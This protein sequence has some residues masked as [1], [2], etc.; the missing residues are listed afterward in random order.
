ML[1]NN[2]QRIQKSHERDENFSWVVCLLS[3][4]G[5]QHAQHQQSLPLT[6][7]L[8]QTSVTCSSDLPWNQ[9]AWICGHWLL[10]RTLEASLKRRTNSLRWQHWIWNGQV[11]SG[12]QL[13]SNTTNRHFSY[14]YVWEKKWGAMYKL[15]YYN[16]AW[17]CTPTVLCVKLLVLLRPL[18]GKKEAL[19]FGW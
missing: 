9:E 13:L 16:V 7:H 12:N 3:W 2:H 10:Q 11:C 19:E 18:F 4:N 14:L 17:I 8:F 15:F 5:R 6:T 1:L